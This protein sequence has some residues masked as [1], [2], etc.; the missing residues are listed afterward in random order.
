MA[1]R[2]TETRAV[3]AVIES[4]VAGS[5][6]GNA[7]LLRSIFHPNAVMVGYLGGNLLS[8]SP[9]PFFQHVARQ[10]PA[11]SS[12]MAE[13]VELQVDGKVACATLV[14]SG[15]AGLDFVDRFHLVE[16][17]GSWRIVSKIFHHD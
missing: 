16:E 3:K 1:D 4:Y 17:G 11:G 15:F 9:E 14:E 10:G 12:Y 7:D 5:R 2:V 6:D 8:G 13:I